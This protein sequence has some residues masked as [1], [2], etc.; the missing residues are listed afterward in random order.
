MRS[1]SPGVPLVRFLAFATFCAL[2]TSSIAAAEIDTNVFTAM[3]W[4][5]IGPFRGGRVTAVAGIP[6][7]PNVYYFGTPGGGIWKS[8]DAGRVWKPIFDQAHVASIGALTV[9]PSDANIIFAGSGEQTPGH[10]VYRSS[11]EGATW[12]NIGLRDLR[13]IQAIA[14]DPHDPNIVVVAGNSL[15]ASVIARHVPKQASLLERGIYKTTDGGK[16]WSKVLAKDDS[17]GVVDLCADPGNPQTLYASVYYPASGKGDSAKAATSEIWKSSDE[18]SS[19]KALASKGLPDKD[20]GR[21]GIVVAP[22]NEGR[23]IYAIVKQG[24]YRSDDGGANWQRSST[25]TRVIGS[26]YFSRIFVDPFNPDVIY[27][28][29]TSLYR[30]TDG[31][32]TFEA[33]RGA[34]GGDDYH[35]LWIDP[36]NSARMLLGVDQGA[37]VSVDAGATWTSWYNQPTGQFYHVS[38]DRYFPYRAYAAQQDSGTAA[39]VTRSDYGQIT[40]H[41]WY[42]VGGFEYCFIAPDPIN[43]DLVYSGGWYGSVLRFDKRTGQYA[44]VFEKGEKYRTAGMAP[45]A[46]APHDPR[47]LYLGT[48]FLMKTSDGGANWQ[49]MSPDLTATSTETKSREKTD[50]KAAEDPD[51]ERRKAI[52]SLSLSTIDSAEI[53]VGTGTGLVQLTRDGGGSWINVSPPGIP[54]T[55]ITGL[56]ASHHDPGTAYMVGNTRDKLVPLLAR[57]YDFGRTWKMIVAGLPADETVRVVR[58]DPVRKGLLYAGTQTGVYVSFD[59]GDT[60]QSLQLNLPAATVTDLDVHENDLVASTFGRALWILDD[61]TPLREM[62]ST[63]LSSDGHLFSPETAMRVRWDTN[64]DTPYPPETPAG[65]NPPN[66]AILNYFL[67]AGT[68]GEITMNIYDAQGKQVQHFSSTPESRE[69]PPPN[70]PSY[71]FAPPEA[72]PKAAGLNRFVWDLRYPAPLAL[73]YGYYGGLL[74]YTEYTLPSDAVPGDTPKLQPQG[75]VAVPGDYTVELS[76]DGKT[77]RKDVKVELDP[78]VKVPV[79]DLQ[80]QLD[81][82]RKIDRGMDVSYRSFHQAEELRKDLEEREKADKAHW[83]KNVKDAVAGFRKKLEG[84][85]SGDPKAPGFGPVNRELGRLAAS[86]QSADVRPSETAKAAVEENCNALEK[87]LAKW[88]QLNAE[89]LGRLNGQLKAGR[90]TPLAASSAISVRACGGEEGLK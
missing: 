47:R 62:N 25:D 70:V 7:K 55:Q 84:I 13:Y 26:E 76:A 15:G 21:L 74:E 54:D 41:D 56:E 60:W 29:Q 23:R 51:Q 66:G 73:P 50:K 8:T 12:T 82:E 39:I 71:W 3:H 75:P 72:L 68:A 34:P 31:G 45:L 40:S 48:Q 43:P 69:L 65:K 4:R 42:P 64:P 30:S 14:V 88:R 58:E 22:S 35:V 5:L 63:V 37:A 46:W 2:G 57:T 49:Q 36:H 89:D 24:F 78:R 86:A 20:R 32:H 27:A 11:D 1:R 33:F 61:L 9:A 6:G 80:Q 79:A 44:T 67:K 19:W 81:L 10:G 87:D 53:W 16:S 28:A 77:F 18:G 38:T 90:E 83:G 52:T 17:A 59:D 85:Q